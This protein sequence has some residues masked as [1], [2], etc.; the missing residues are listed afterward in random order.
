MIFSGINPLYQLERFSRGY[1]E[2]PSID[3]S[4][5]AVILSS[6]PKSGNTWIRFVVS[7]IASITKAGP[8][9]DFKSI[10]QFAPAIRGNRALNGALFVEGLP[11][12]LKSHSAY[13]PCFSAYKSV[14]VVRDPFKAVP[15]YREYLIKAKEKNMP[16]IEGF[17]RHWRYGLNAWAQ[18]VSSWDKHATIVVKYEDLQ[19]NQEVGIQKIY[20]DLGVNVAL[21]VIQQAVELSSRK[22]M[23]RVLDE[24]GDPNNH[25]GFQFVRDAKENQGIRHYLNN[26][27]LENEFPYFVTQAKKYGYY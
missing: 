23:K 14:V 21:D 24:K 5:H 13:V 17:C 18:F 8:D 10:E 7:N 20:S 16:D 22:S 19:D 27:Q 2:C 11:I 9:V 6:Y 26:A 3:Y 12:F 4:E 25:N 15:S 1:W